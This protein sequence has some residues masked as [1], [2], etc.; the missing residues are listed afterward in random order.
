MATS[1]ID[2]VNENVIT[3]VSE[4][5]VLTFDTD[6]DLEPVVTF[7]D[8]EIIIP[9]NTNVDEH[10]VEAKELVVTVSMEDTEDS[11][12]SEKISDDEVLQEETPKNEE[13]GKDAADATNKKRKKAEKRKKKNKKSGSKETK[14]EQA[15]VSADESEKQDMH[16]IRQK[17]LR[18]RQQEIE[19]KNREWHEQELFRSMW[20]SLK[21]AKEKGTILTGVISGLEEISVDKNNQYIF[22]SIIYED[23]L[24]ILIPF[25]ELYRDNPIR[26]SVD[27]TTKE[28]RKSYL[29]R[30]KAM[31]E[32]LY[33]LETPFIITNMA[34]GSNKDNTD[35]SI[36]ASRKKALEILERTNFEPDKKTGIA[37]YEVGSDIEATIISVGKYGVVA[38]VGGIDTM[39]AARQM[40]FKYIAG[41]ETVEALFHVGQK[42]NVHV[43]EITTDEFGHRKLVV[44]GRY[45]ELRDARSRQQTLLSL[46]SFCVGTITSIAQS[47]TRP[48]AV[49]IRMYL[50]NYRM[51]AISNAIPPSKAGK[52]PMPGDKARVKVM[53]FRPDG[54]VL[55]QFRG[56]HGAP[57][58]T[59]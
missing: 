52:F 14:K 23:R 4:N 27:L 48:D 15:P 29:Q 59:L 28:G 54:M 35:Y 36:A 1:K 18:E 38:S 33:G 21:S 32:K 58:Y 26:D 30:Q 42:V 16:D 19:Q 40:T 34:K 41:P 11:Q 25:I 2:N 22:V 24:K 39:I 6:D 37:R 5:E 31:A 44:D 55:V 8:G 46:N 53:G 45:A 13:E 51:P 57:N 9:Q 49:V 47:K 17:L 50:D 12:E 7:E 3:A 43:R 10:N 56:L 20:N